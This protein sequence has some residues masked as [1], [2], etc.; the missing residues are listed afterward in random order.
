MSRPG[1]SEPFTDSR[2]ESREHLLQLIENI[3]DY[4]IFMLDARGHVASWNSGAERLKG[5]TAKEI[6]GRH[7]SCFYPAEAIA[8]RKPELELRQAIEAGY[9]EDEGW[10]IRK[11][12]TRFWANVVIT[13]LFDKERNLLG[14]GK[15]TRDL[16]ERKKIE[17]L[18]EA[19]RQKD[20]FL[21]LLGH[22]LR[23][24]LA[25]VHNSLN[26]ISRPE[27][28][29]R[30]VEEARKIAD[31]QVRQMTRLVDDLLDVA[32]ISRG[33]M[34]LRKNLVDIA[35]IINRA[36]DA[37]RAS[38]ERRRHRLTVTVPTG[39]LWIKA[40]PARIEQVIA[41][42]LSNATKYTE[43]GGQILVQ[44]EKDGTQAVVKI[45][46]SGIGIDP[47]ALPHIFNLF[48]QPVRRVDRSE[49]GLGLGLALVKEIVELHGGSVEAFSAGV[50][51]GSEFVV[52]LP[53]VCQTQVHTESNVDFEPQGVE[54][55]PMRIL[56]A[57]D[58]VDSADCLARLL[59]IAGHELRVAYDGPT[60]LAV[61]TSFQPKVVL[62]DIG[63]PGLN[64]YEVAQRLRQTPKT[65]NATL[66]AITG[67]GEPEDQRKAREAGFDYH[68]LKP[69]TPETLQQLLASVLHLVD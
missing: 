64:G 33:K 32:R 1:D 2:D 43:T 53:C 65:K 48:V 69:V 61:A 30:D 25:A 46:D 51:Q 66:V 13:A 34:K 22:E 31:R 54:T 29:E 38:I 20:Q 62:L 59:T 18:Q 42:L 28:S 4:A 10:R 40:D 39:P 55:P 68:L 15:I 49:P 9:T 52:C 47:E 21:A 14:F 26:V 24:P 5:Y 37:C 23:T 36:V 50:G 57:D 3:K 41:N 58:N 12:G 44:A 35:Q 7:F 67:W 8:R 17:W 63:I 60:A 56:V 6:I 27:A 11:D 45:R 19:D 16:T